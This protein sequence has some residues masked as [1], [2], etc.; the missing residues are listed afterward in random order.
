MFKITEFSKIAHVSR[1]LLQYYDEIDLFKPVFTHPDSG[2]RFYSVEQLP[3]LH[4]ILA[5]KDLGLTLDQVARMADDNISPD[6]IRGM[7]NLKKAQIEQTLREEAL[8]LHHVEMRLHQLQEYGTLSSYDVILKEVPPQDF[9]SLRKRNS[10]TESFYDFFYGVLRFAKQDAFLNT[11][12][13]YVALTH[14]EAHEQDDIDI[15]LG[16]VLDK[17]PPSRDLVVY[18]YGLLQPTM[19]AGVELMASLIVTGEHGFTGFEAIGAWI[20]ANGYRIVGHNREL[21]WK[22]DVPDGN[23]ASETVLEIQFPVEQRI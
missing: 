22:I 8:R 6:E 10:S 15:E 1:R 19:L 23:A 3:R 17:M 14:S 2:Y 9:L 20:E 7:L 12:S 21:Y 4:R 5:L 11:C 18:A 16:F 13:P